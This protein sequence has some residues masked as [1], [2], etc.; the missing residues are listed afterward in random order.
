MQQGRSLGITFK[1]YEN[2][3]QHQKRNTECG[4]YALFM[5]V[6]LIEGTRT[7]EEF[8]RGVRIPDNHMLEFRS[9]YFNRGGSI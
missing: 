3:K 8:M 4:M 9:E 6:N 5:I 7:P 1:Y 2:R